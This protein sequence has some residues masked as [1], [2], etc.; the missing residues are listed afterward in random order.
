M[1]SRPSSD[2]YPAGLTETSTPTTS[3]RT[4]DKVKTV[5]HE[6]DPRSRLRALALEDRLD[7]T[8]Q[9]VDWIK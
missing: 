7:A 8:V 2:K 4:G 9:S 5:T 6:V 3:L 1:A